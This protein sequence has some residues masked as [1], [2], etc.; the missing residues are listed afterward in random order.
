MNLGISSHFVQFDMLFM[1]TAIDK[2]IEFIFTVPT[3]A[4]HAISSTA[5]LKG[6]ACLPALSTRY[7]VCFHL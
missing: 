5:L 4:P 3:G 6:L 1:I 7:L 2:A